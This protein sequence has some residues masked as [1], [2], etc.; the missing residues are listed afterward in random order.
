MTRNKVPPAFIG[1]LLIVFAAVVSLPT[2]S[3]AART[4]A[5]EAASTPATPAASELPRPPALQAAFLRGGDL[6]AKLGARERRLARPDEPI[7]DLA[8]SPDGAWLAYATGEPAAPSAIRAV[9]VAT[10]EERL[11][12][13]GCR[14]PRWA[15][16]RSALAYAADDGIRVA[17]FPP[18]RRVEAP[19]PVYG[20]APGQFGWLP[21]DEG[22]LVASQATREDGEWQPISLYEVKLAGDYA[23]VPAAGE[24]RPLVTLPGM[25]DDFFAV[26]LS[27]FRWSPDGRQVAFIAHPT[28]SLS[29]DG[30]W[31]CVLNRDGSGFRKIGRMLAR[32]DWF[33]WAPPSEPAPSRLGFIEGEGR[34]EVSDKRFAYRDVQGAAK[35][36]VTPPGRMDLGFAWLGPSRVVVARAPELDWEEGPVP[37][38][39]AS[40]FAIELPGG[41]ARRLTKPAAGKS[42]RSPAYIPA[43]RILA[44]V[45]AEADGIRADAWTANERGGGAAPFIRNV[46]APPVWFIPPA[47]S[48]QPEARITGTKTPDYAK[49]G[50]LAMRE[51]SRRYGGAIVDYEHLG[52]VPAGPGF[53]EERF[54]FWVRGDDEQFG[55]Y[56]TIRFET[57]SER[58]VRLELRKESN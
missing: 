46:D 50:R 34:F 14:Q 8:W 54:R 31:L 10:G 23:A 52:R 29:A 11:V 58:V 42:D 21:D 13:E 51:T 28:A 7:V 6:W 20:K 41:E 49:W 17:D 38:A 12:C 36:R 37:R 3:T 27:P 4:P 15:N 2:S 16:R 5:P 19:K 43:S 47:A 1:S 30:N 56:A 53:A 39:E 57:E 35:P 33:A 32:N 44:W 45:R 55:V 18:G 40:L 25:S 22:L 26:S 9:Q 48:R 24:P